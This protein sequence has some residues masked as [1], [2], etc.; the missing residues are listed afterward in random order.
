MLACLGFIAIIALL[1]GSAHQQAARMGR[2]V[3]G[4]YDHAFIGM[5]YVD[6]TQ[7]EFL[8]LLATYGEAGPT[9]SPETRWANLP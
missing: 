4:I 7:E 3:I 1:G 9:P 2:L 5:A 6:Q 8:R